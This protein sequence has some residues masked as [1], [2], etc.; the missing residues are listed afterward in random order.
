M[1]TETTMVVILNLQDSHLLTLSFVQV[2][3]GQYRPVANLLV[4]DF[5][6]QPREMLTLKPLNT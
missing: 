3:G 6:S 1:I 4:V 2:N 5:H